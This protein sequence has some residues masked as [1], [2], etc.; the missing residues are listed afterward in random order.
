MGPKKQEILNYFKK[1]YVINISTLTLRIDI[2]SHNDKTH[3]N[4]GK[5]CYYSE[6]NPIREINNW[7]N[8]TNLHR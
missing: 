4:Y 6:I 1:G 3:N 7:T 2:C 8:K 5:Q